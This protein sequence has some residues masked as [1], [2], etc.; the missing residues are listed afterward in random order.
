[1]KFYWAFRHFLCEF[2][3]TTS[4]SLA[5]R[6][7]KLTHH[8]PLDTRHNKAEVHFEVILRHTLTYFNDTGRGCYFICIIFIFLRLISWSFSVKYA[9]CWIPQDF[10]SNMSTLIHVTV[11]H[12]SQLSHYLNAHWPSSMTSYD[13]TRDTVSEVNNTSKYDCCSFLVVI[14]REY[15]QGTL[16]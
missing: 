2:S 15:I 9:L 1:M 4:R 3:S 12:V 10:D 13:V 14:T 5:N 6:E 7:T 16:P 11:R 8:G